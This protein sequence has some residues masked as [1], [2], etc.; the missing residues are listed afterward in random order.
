MQKFGEMCIITNKDNIHWDKLA[1]CGTHRI[2]VSQAENY[3]A[4]T[5]Q[6][7]NPKRKKN[8]LT[9]DVTFLQ[10]S[11]GEYTRADKPVVVTTSYQG[12]DEEEELKTIP[13]FNN[14]NNVN[15]VSDSYTDSSEEDSKNSKDNFSTKMSMTKPKFL[16][17]PPSTQKW[18]R[19]VPS[20]I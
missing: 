19:K 12:L 15:I 1:D 18:M 8:I 9:Q 13:I 20:K 2:W 10:K 6:I 17:K 3:T 5:Y 7:F 16:P 14:N 4:G 11:Y